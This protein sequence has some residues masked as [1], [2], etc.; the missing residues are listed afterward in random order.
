MHTYTRLQCLT[1]AYTI[2]IYDFLLTAYALAFLNISTIIIISTFILLCIIRI[3]TINPYGEAVFFSL[4]QNYIQTSTRY[5]RVAVCCVYILMCSCYCIYFHKKNN[6][7]IVCYAS[8][9]YPT[10][11]NFDFRRW[12]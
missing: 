10:K 9:V 3:M 11:T 4:F 1:R 6:N 2:I 7:I 8:K 5:I 12:T